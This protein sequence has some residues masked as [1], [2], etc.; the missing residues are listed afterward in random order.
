MQAPHAQLLRKNQS[1]LS[2]MLVMVYLLFPIDSL[3]DI[4]SL[5]LNIISW[6]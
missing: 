5:S 4:A 1:Q 6:W 3:V 2:N